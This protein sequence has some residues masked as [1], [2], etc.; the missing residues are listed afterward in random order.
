[1]YREHLT[2]STCLTHNVHC[3]GCFVIVRTQREAVAFLR[4]IRS[5]EM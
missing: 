4:C 5:R 1:M 3:R 2:H